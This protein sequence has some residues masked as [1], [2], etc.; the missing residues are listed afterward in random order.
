MNP[1]AREY[2]LTLKKPVSTADAMGGRAKTW[3]KV[4]DAWGKFKRPRTHTAL[5]QG[6]VAAVVTQ[7]IIIPTCEAYPGYRVECGGHTYA[8]VGVAPEDRRYIT[9]ICEEVEHHAN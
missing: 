6:G 3:T 8:V 5:V 1:G 4:C 9:L 7:E 2:Q